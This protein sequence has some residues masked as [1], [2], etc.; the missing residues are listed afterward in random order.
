M[1]SEA[2]LNNSGRIYLCY[3][4][5][6]IVVKTAQVFHEEINKIQDRY[7]PF[8]FLIIPN[9][10][11]YLVYWSC[12]YLF[13]ANHGPF[14]F[15]CKNTEIH[16]SLHLELAPWACIISKGILL[17]IQRKS[18]FV[19]SDQTRKASLLMGRTNITLQ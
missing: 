16:G 5:P 7:I 8:L 15:D 17:S 6:I 19:V 18:V 3:Y 1:Y 12:N 13:Q 4:P 2:S 14:Y 10:L 9:M 11:N